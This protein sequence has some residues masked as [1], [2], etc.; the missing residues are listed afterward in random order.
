MPT[1]RYRAKRK[2]Y[3][4]NILFDEDKEYTLHVDEQADP[5]IIPPYHLEPLDGGPVEP[6]PNTKLA[7]MREGRSARAYDSDIQADPATMH[8]S[9]KKDKIVTEGK[10]PR[11]KPRGRQT[12]AQK[13]ASKAKSAK[14]KKDRPKV[15]KP[16]ATPP[17]LS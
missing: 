16:R 12:A 7:R 13:A 14:A 11:S 10:A 5:P 2:C 1:H 15:T 8:E 3:W 17:A 9:A 4:D 6:V